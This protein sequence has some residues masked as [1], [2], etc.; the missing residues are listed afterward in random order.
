MTAW[1]MYYSPRELRRVLEPMLPQARWQSWRTKHLAAASA[2]V[3]DI[4]EDIVKYVL[5][6]PEATTR[7][8][9]RQIN[10]H[11]AK[12][13]DDDIASET[14]VFLNHSPSSG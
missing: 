2:P 9:S 7:V 13:Y 6:R 14:V 11:L 1:L 5:S 3:E 8:S 12:E 4:A 10:S